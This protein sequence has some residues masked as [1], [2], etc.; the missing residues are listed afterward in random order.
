[1][2]WEPPVG[3]ILVLFEFMFLL[4]AATILLGG[5]KMLIAESKVEVR[6]SHRLVFFCVSAL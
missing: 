2:C 5:E 3:P 4:I 1:M 6:P